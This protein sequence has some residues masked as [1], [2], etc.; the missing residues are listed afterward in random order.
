MKFFAA[1]TSLSLLVIANYASAQSKR[2]KDNAVRSAV[3]AALASGRLDLGSAAGLAGC[4]EPAVFEAWR[5]HA[6]EGAAVGAPAG[7]AG[8]GA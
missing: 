6:I 5:R 1:A 3:E 8:A 7:A 2:E 4:S